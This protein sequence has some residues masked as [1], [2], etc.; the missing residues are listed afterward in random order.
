MAKMVFIRPY[1]ETDVTW[2]VIRTSCNLGMW[3]MAS[4]LK[5]KGHSGWYLD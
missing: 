3:Y 1:L 4:D 5:Q 2:E